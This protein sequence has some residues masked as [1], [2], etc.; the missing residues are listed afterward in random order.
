LTISQ[1]D[2]VRVAASRMMIFGVGGLVVDDLPTRE[3]GLVTERD[4]VR[5]I[6]RIKSIE[7]L[8]EAM[9]YESEATPNSKNQIIKSKNN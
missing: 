1:N 3:I 7:F 8:V 9:R 6:S 4:L 5:Q 2:D